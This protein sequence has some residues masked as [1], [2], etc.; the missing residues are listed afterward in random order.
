MIIMSYSELSKEK[1]SELYEKLNKEYKDYCDKNLKLDMSR[2][3]PSPE[4]L[5][6]C[7]EMLDIKD[8]Y[9]EAGLDTRNYGILEGIPEARKLMGELIGVKA[10]NAIIGGNS[11][12]N[13]MF[14]A[15][16]LGF[17]HGV[18]GAKLPWSKQEKIKFLC[19][20]PGYDRHF[21]ITEFFGFEMITVP[22][23]ENGPD[24][25]KVEE[26]VNNDPAVKGI[27]CVPKYSNPTG[28]TYSDEVV[29]RFA[30]LKPAADDFRIFW[31]NAY[32]IHFLDRNDD[33]KL[34]NIYD[35]CVKNG[36]EDMVYIFGSTSKISFAGAGVAVMGA[37]KNNLDLLAKQEGVKTIGSDKI[38]QLRHVK[39]YKDYEGLLSCMEK[40]AK[41]MKPKFEM[42][43]K[44][45][46]EELSGTDTG[47]WNSVKGG[48]FIALDTMEG[49]AKRT[50]ELCKN[51]GVVMTPAGATYPYG[52]D[53]RDSTIRIAPSY[54]SPAELEIA[55]KL[56][57]L[58]VKIAAVE[59]LLN[60]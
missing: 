8:V 51:A 15:V 39:Y 2:G 23:D 55:A 30:A 36:T 43:L 57:C 7:M 46:D 17:T 12:L 14:D 32:A 11:S 33:D 6:I 18:Y 35:E 54:P 27:W 42:V 59:K 40:H 24:M 26:L 41:I 49:C 22:M 37:S 60:K 28:I 34:L 47:T 56:L 4:Q 48:Y 25:N 10:E 31:D 52:N 5:D 1:L 9:T 58:C 38:N 44:T 53:F 29:K 20:V 45:L 19:P 16:A 21:R 50:L 13:M 3:K